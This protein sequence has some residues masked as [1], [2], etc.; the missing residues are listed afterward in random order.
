MTMNPGSYLFGHGTI[1]GAT[2]N[3]T[4]GSSTT[5]P[6]APPYTGVEHI[7]FTSGAT[8]LS[9]IYSWRLD[10]LDDTPSNAGTNWSLLDFPGGATLGSQ[11][12]PFFLSLDFGPGVDDPNSGDAFWT[13]PHQ[14]LVADTPDRFSGVSLIS[15]FPAFLQG[16]F[17]AG[18]DTASRNLYVSYAAVPEPGTLVMSAFGVLGLLVWTRRRKQP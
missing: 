12:Y 5:D 2:I 16:L 14:W 13:L 18:V 4:I 15:P 11:N 1:S 7:T 10:S 6:A 8:L 9:A 3:G 17:S